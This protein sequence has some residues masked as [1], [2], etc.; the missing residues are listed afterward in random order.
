[1]FQS[2]RSIIFK[3]VLDTSLKNQFDFQ[4]Q[5]ILPLFLKYQRKRRILIDLATFLAHVLQLP[6]R[7]YWQWLK[8]SNFM[9]KSS[10]DRHFWFKSV[11]NFKSPEV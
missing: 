5:D 7:I 8:N 2:D 1:M 4:E 3:N 6:T 11:K 10:G 9:L